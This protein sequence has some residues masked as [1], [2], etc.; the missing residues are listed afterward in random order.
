ME[1]IFY[2]LCIIY[3][4]CNLVQLIDWALVPSY[5]VL[6]KNYRRLSAMQM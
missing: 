4:L 6:A 3:R 1:S 2:S 5:E